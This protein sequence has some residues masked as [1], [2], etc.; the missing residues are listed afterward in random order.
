M[1]SP[2]RCPKLRVLIIGQHNSFEHVLTTNIQNWGYEAIVL[3]SSALSGSEAEGDILLFDLDEASRIAMGMGNERTRVRV[4]VKENVAPLS[5]VGNSIKKYEQRWPHVRLKIALSS[6]SVSR[7]TLE[8]IG[9]VALLQTPFEMGRLQRYLQVLQRLLL[10]REAIKPLNEKLRILVVDDDVA[11]ASAVEQCLI[12][13]SN[14][15]VAVAHDGLEALEQCLD[16]K[17]HCIVTDLIMPWMNGYQVMRCL[18]A[19]SLHARPA[20]V[21]MSALTQLE[22]PWNRSYMR[23]NQVAYVDKPFNIDHLLSAIEQV[24]LNRA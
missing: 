15:E 7:S 4:P 20:F 9:A 5:L 3:P 16:W 14:Y 6:H 18:N 11:I 8:Q 12:F 17:P 24:C 19:A 23:G 21:I 10:E 22:V 2:R 13:E 1:Q